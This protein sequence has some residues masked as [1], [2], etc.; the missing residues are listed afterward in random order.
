MNQ[1]VLYPK[2]HEET[3]ELKKK[4]ARTR[5]IQKM[6]LIYGGRT[7]AAKCGACV[8]LKVHQCSHVYFKCEIYSVT[9]GMATDWRVGYDACGKFKQ[10]ETAI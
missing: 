2:T 7:S 3:V 8:H 6:H 5:G 1:K 4:Y 10:K 9:R